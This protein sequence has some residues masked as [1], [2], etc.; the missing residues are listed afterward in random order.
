MSSGRPAGDEVKQ[1]LPAESSNASDSERKKVSRLRL[2]VKMLK[3]KPVVESGEND[4]SDDSSKFTSDV[5][6]QDRQLLSDVYFES[7]Y[8]FS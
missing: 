3:C 7:C 1:V 8:H 4:D 5:T 2:L 6:G